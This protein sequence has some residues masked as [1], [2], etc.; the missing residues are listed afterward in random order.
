MSGAWSV[1][2]SLAGLE[3]RAAARNWWF[4]LYAVVFAVLAGGVGYVSSSD[5]AGVEHG[6]FGRTAAGLV[7]VVLLLIP[8]FG[9]LAGAGAIANDRERGMLAYFLAQPISHAQ[10]FWGKYLGTAIA[11]IGALAIGFAVAAFSLAVSG[12]IEPLPYLLLVGLA[13]LLSLAALSIGMLI[14]VLSRRSALAGG[15]AVFVWV[16]LL[17]LGDLGLMATVVATKLDLR[18]VVG[19]ALL[20]PAELFKVAS[21]REIGASLDALGPAGVYLVTS[22][23]GLLRPLLAGLLATW[24]VAPALLALW[25]FKQGDAA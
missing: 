16:S 15:L 12:A 5:L 10:L 4:G 13:V 2:L 20:N 1:T 25:V 23:G 19:V 18:L 3:L 14:S 9:L 7:N 8:L 11:L 22:L 24:V 6:E 21:I 17:F